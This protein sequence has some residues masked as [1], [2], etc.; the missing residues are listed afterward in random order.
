MVEPK[1]VDRQKIAFTIEEVQATLAKPRKVSPEAWAR[2]DKW[3]GSFEGPQD[4]S[5][6]LDTYLYGINHE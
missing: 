6:N 3:V 4:L 1:V 2:F 5:L